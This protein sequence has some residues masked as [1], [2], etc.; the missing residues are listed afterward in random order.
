M[1]SVVNDTTSLIQHGTE[2]KYFLYHQNTKGEWW[3]YRGFC[4]VWQSG[5][6]YPLHRPG[7]LHCY[8][9]IS[10]HAETITD[11][12]ACR[13]AFKKRRYLATQR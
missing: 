11:K 8:S 13:D 4:A 7:I 3:N 5:F 6:L 12:P 2:I 9:M 10:A 1:P